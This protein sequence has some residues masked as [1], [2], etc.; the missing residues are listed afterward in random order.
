MKRYMDINEFYVGV[1]AKYKK[2]IIFHDWKIFK[3]KRSIINRCL[4][5]GI[6]NFIQLLCQKKNK[7]T[8]Q[9]Y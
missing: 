4:F 6:L 9:F 7:Y 3:G 5:L 2:K 1:I 8:S